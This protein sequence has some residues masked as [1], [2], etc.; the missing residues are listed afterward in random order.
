MSEVAAPGAAD[1]SNAP[2]V[3]IR[4]VRPEEYDAAASVLVT[5]YDHDY[6]L[7]EEYRENLRSIEH[8]ATAQQVWVAVD[9]DPA[10]GI[11]NLLGL[12]ITPRP[13]GPPIAPLARAGELDFRLLAVHPSARRRGIGELLTHHVIA[14]ARSRGATAV[15]MNSGPDMIAAHRLYARLG[16]SRLPEREDRWVQGPDGPFRLFAFGLVL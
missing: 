3:V 15:V 16:F 9:P 13:D 1:R 5:A 6:T 4:P 11:P 10:P 2:E 12:V 14:L 7:T 8:W